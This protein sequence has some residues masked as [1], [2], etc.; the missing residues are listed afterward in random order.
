[1]PLSALAV[2][3][4]KL[5]DPHHTTFAV[6]GLSFQDPVTGNAVYPLSPVAALFINT[7]AAGPP[8]LALGLEPT[9]WDAM[10][11]SPEAYRTIFTR[12]WW[13]DLFFYGFLIGVRSSICTSTDAGADLFLITLSFR[14]WASPHLPFPSMQARSTAARV[15]S[16][17][18]ATTL[19]TIQ[20]SAKTS[21]TAARPA[22]VPS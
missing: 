2:W 1:M 5:A 20:P 17:P 6:I 19:A 13:M 11:K 10:F 4:K 22:S 14:V 9:A 7:I 3:R 15:S 16:T 18:A 12:W 8:A 21:I